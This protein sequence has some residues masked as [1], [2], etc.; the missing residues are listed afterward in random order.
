MARPR[1]SR[2]ALVTLTTDIGAAYAAQMK[3]VLARALPPGHVIDLAHDLTPHAVREAGFLLQA[4]ARG[5]PPG[6]VHVAVVDPG[7]GGSR[8]PIVARCADGS[9]LIGPNNGVLGP[10]AV[11]LGR[12][13][14][15]RIERTGLAA[16]PRVGVT[17]DGRDLFAPAA[18]AA[19]LGRRPESF[20]PPVRLR[21]LP[22]APLRLSRR[23]A[24]GEVAHIDR[25][26]NLVTNVPTD[27]APAAPSSLD[28][29]I[30]RA[31]RLRL[32]LVTHYEALGRGRAGVLGSSFGL[33]EIAV[34]RG[35]ADRRFRARTS[36]AVRFVR[37][38][39]PP[40]PLRG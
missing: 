6:T 22:G 38:R 28:V 36:T 33:L 27:W 3:G 21:R 13:C 11:A 35:R 30:G 8:A 18:A 9:V 40:G 23:T 14:A 39:V 37:P 16:G 20:G 15:F 34:D 2:P 10:L 32:P 26:G 25:F 4:M 7:V 17:F 29:V 1:R 12:P 19:A 5:F 24:V 31:R